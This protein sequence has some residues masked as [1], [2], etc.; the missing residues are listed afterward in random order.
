MLGDG[1]GKATRKKVKH[2]RKKV[3][4]VERPLKGTFP[5]GKVIYAKYKGKDYKAWVRT[6]GGIKF[7]GQLYDS[8]SGAARAIIERG[9]VNGWNFWK[10]KDSSGNLVPLHKLRK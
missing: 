8:P 2:R 1:K 7:K 5:G 4:G 6:N 10:Y 3:K 9:A